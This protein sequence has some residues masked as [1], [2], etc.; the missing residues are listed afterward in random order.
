M[1]EIDPF[2]MIVQHPRMRPRVSTRF[3]LQLNIVDENGKELAFRLTPHDMTYLRHTIA[4]ADEWLSRNDLAAF[5]IG[6]DA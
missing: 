4:V 2:G 1:A 6:D 5:E 3:G